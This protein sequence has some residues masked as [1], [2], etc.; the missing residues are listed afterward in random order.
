MLSVIEPHVEWFVEARREIF[1]RRIVA[2]DICVADNAHRYRGGCE[3][4]AVTV[5]AGFVTGEAWVCG[6]VGSLVTRVTGEGT[7]SLARVKEF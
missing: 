5:S 7:V 6:V 4:S 2:G 3:L 1:Q